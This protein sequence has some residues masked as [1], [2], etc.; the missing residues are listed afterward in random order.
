[1]AAATGA[2]VTKLATGCLEKCTV[3]EAG[4]EPGNPGRATGPVSCP[5]SCGRSHEKAQS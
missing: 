2:F 5:V 3:R 1:M 4:A